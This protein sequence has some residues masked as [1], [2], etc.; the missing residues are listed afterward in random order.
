MKEIKAII[1]PFMLVHVLDALMRIDQLP[2]LTISDVKGWG[3]SRAVGV[4]RPVREAGHAF[5]RKTKVEVVV[6]DDMV[7][8]VVGA[9][10][11][12]ARTGKPGDGKVFVYELA[13]AVKVRS[14]E[15]G[16]SAV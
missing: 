7:E 8:Q 16:E 11:R 6:T 4:R 14:G 9:V 1:Q 5:A 3:K 13:E 2:G 15:R 10:V 12:A